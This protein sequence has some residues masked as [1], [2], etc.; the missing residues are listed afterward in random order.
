MAGGREQAA[1]MP[2]GVQPSPNG[3]GGRMSGGL[4]AGAAAGLAAS[5]VQVVVGKTEQW[6]F[7][8]HGETPDFAPRLVDRAFQRAYGRASAPVKW[9]LGTLFHLG[10]GAFWGAVYGAAQRRLRLHPLLTGAGLGLLI[11]GITF[12]RWGAAVRFGVERPPQAR[13]RRMTAVAASVAMAYGLAVGAFYSRLA[14]R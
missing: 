11:Y 6:L 10:Y 5:V 9:A 4:A 3:A 1:G 2:G 14:R 12:P 8:P 7:L 13:T